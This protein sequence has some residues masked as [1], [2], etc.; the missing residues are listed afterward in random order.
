MRSGF[1]CAGSHNHQL[2]L[3]TDLMRKTDSTNVS[4]NSKILIL[5]EIPVSKTP[6]PPHH[7][8]VVL[9]EDLVLGDWNSSDEIL[10][11]KHK[12]KPA[13]EL[14][15]L[16]FLFLHLWN[17]TY[18][19]NSEKNNLGLSFL[20]GKS[21]TDNFPWHAL[22]SSLGNKPELPLPVSGSVFSYLSISWGLNIYSSTKVR[23]KIGL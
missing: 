21:H 7:L 22:I 10:V 23:F 11:R 13:G 16:T 1:T 14:E 9:S 18:F 19:S 12:I 8:G 6:L 17:S 15:L 5:S 4:V 20:T 3:P 2:V